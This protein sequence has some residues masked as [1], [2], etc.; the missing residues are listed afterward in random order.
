VVKPSHWLA[1]YSLTCDILCNIS[2]SRLVAPTP[3]GTGGG[4]VPHFSKWLDTIE[5]G[6]VSRGTANK[7]LTKLY[8]P[9]RKRWPKRLV[10]LLEQKKSGGARPRKIYFWRFA[11]YRCPPLLLQ[12]GAPPFNFVPTPLLSIEYV[13]ARR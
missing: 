7:K 5:G 12:P 8:W 6:T 2:A 9:S 3:W 1:Q 4:H 13:D 10:V 11:P